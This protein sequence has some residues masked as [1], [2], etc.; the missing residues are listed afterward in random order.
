MKLL[1]NACKYMAVGVVTLSMLGCGALST[2]VE[3]RNLNVQTRMSDTI[4]LEPAAPEQQIV[5]VRVRNTSDKTDFNIESEIVNSLQSKGYRITKRPDDAKYWLDAVVKS[6]TSTSNSSADQALGGGFGG[7]VLGGALGAATSNHADQGKGAVL[8]ALA[9]AAV[10]AVADS[11]VQDIT[12]MAVVDIQITEKLSH[13]A[14]V[15]SDSEQKLS[16]GASGTQHQVTTN[17]GNSMKYQSRV[18]ATA[19]KA[20]LKYEEAGPK[21]REGIVRSLSGLF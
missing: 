5:W 2:S 3:K 12:F 9:G 6:V 8:G 10:G 20:N 11:L 18:V 1:T 13:G 14:V 19:N 17:T 7:A 4:Y 15:K 16:Q 21:L